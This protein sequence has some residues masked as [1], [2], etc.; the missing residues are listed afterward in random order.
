MS[1]KLQLQSF[2]DWSK[3]QLIDEIKKLRKRKKYGL[4]WEDKPEDVAERCKVELPVLKEVKNRAIIR[5]K[6]GPT[7]ILIEGDNYH[8]LSVLNYTHK[9]KI[10]VIYIDPPY[11]TGSEGFMYNDK[12]VNKEDTYRHSKWLSF[13]EKRLRLAKNL[14]KNDGIIFISIDDNEFAQLRLLMDYFFPEGSMKT[15]IIWQK[16]VRPSNKNKN[17]FSGTTEYILMYSKSNEDIKLIP[18]DL[19]ADYVKK[20]YKNP[21]NDSRGAWRGQPL[22]SESNTNKRKTLV[23][24]DGR[25]I[26]QKWFISQDTLNEL[27]ADNKILESKNGVLNAKSF[28]QERNGKDPMN[29]LMGEDVGTTEEATKELKEIMGLS[30][31]MFMY[32]KPTRLI[33]FLISRIP[34][35][36]DALILDFFAGSGTTGQAVLELNREDGG[37]RH[38][39]LCTNNENKIASEICYPRLEKVINE[40]IKQK[41]DKNIPTRNNLRYFRTAFVEAEPN[42]KNKEKLTKEAVEMLCMREDTFESVKETNTI[43][44]YK[45]NK[46][47]TG[48]VFDEDVIPAIKKE[49]A[50]IGGKWNVFIF[51]LGDDTFDDEFEDMKQKIT[52]SPIPEVILRVYRRLFKI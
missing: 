48:I 4:V 37:N 6:N 32:P 26:T 27:F 51:S 52:V 42:D 46:Q 44:I 40:K 14:L 21:D 29:L 28:L 13:M 23:L 36:K 16:K 49:I 15:T 39:I 43:K 45:N 8:A 31:N 38:F 7:N 18:V 35:N 50:K 2:K 24:P 11:N 33:S 30:E 9:G 12:I 22:W 1:E 3:E 19:D 17:G 20:V 47:Y 5:D 41:K 34:N 25:E 10:D